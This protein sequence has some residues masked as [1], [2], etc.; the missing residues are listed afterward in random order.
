MC[1][2]SVRSIPFC[3]DG[4]AKRWGLI[5]R[6][7]RT[8]F[9]SLLLL[10]IALA[11][12]LVLPLRATASE[13]IATLTL[14]QAMAAALKYNQSL[15]LTKDEVF[16][17]EI[18]VKQKKDNFLP[19]VN[20]DGS[21]G[22]RHDQGSI[23]SA[24]DYQSLSAEVS[25]SMNLFNG[26]GDQAALEQ[27]TETLA[28]QQKIYTRQQQTLVF[29]TVSA[30][31]GAVKNLEQIQVA[32]QTLED[33]QRQLADIEAY[34][35]VGRRPVTDVY[36][37]QAETARARSE[38]LA[39]Q[40][41]YQV[42]KLTLMQTL[43]VVATTQFE[44][45]M[46]KAAAL[47]DAPG[48]DIASLI[49]QAMEQRPDLLAKEREQRAVGAQERLALA[50]AY[51][52][53]DLVVGVGSG[54]DS[55]TDSGFGSQMDE[56]NLYGNAGLNLSIPL[57]DRHLTRNEVSQ[58]RISRHSVDL[59]REQLQ[60]QIEVEIGQAVQEYLTATDQVEVAKAQLTYAQEALNS[61][62]QRYRV[63]AATLTELTDAR[64]TFVEARY[65]LVE[66]H[67][68]RMLRTVAIIY[69]RG[70]LGG[71]MFVGEGEV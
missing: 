27:A 54:Y 67:V 38:L 16:S 22:F 56:D 21:V 7:H 58:A 14:E 20:A 64:S 35:R 8:F 26:F 70:D 25:A 6:I 28:A 52:T 49:R 65:A 36:K 1:G 11:V 2:L 17:Q 32:Q 42:G 61:T 50:G 53:L 31:L 4:R 66:A 44:V 68:D 71:A 48:T 13:Q 33:N 29:D 41:D 3:S 18:T 15:R 69:Y 51:P 34:Y 47:S 12:A 23:G 57:F 62:E 45:A 55:R 5:M 46:P 40:R 9:G 60:R 43:G 24:R 59:E 19:E 39:A 63:G 37:Q 10:G 30:Y